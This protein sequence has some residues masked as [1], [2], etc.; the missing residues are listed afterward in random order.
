MNEKLCTSTSPVERNDYVADEGA[1]QVERRLEAN[2]EQSAGVD[3][4]DVL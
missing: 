4:E 2:P 1:G 3:R